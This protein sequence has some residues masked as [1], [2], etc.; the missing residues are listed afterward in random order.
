ME[1]IKAPEEGYQLFLIMF[2]SL[3]RIAGS[4]VFYRHGVFLLMG[5]V[6]LIL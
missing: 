2:F 1:K 3:Q 6:T 5:R 4:N